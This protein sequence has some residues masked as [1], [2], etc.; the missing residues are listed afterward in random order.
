[1]S[2][3]T[4]EPPRRRRLRR[5]ARLLLWSAAVVAVLVALV[6]WLGG[7][8]WARE[9]VR[10]LVEARLT[11][12][13]GREVSIASVDYGVAPLH[14]SARGIT[15]AGARSDEPPF[16]RVPALRV[17]LRIVGVLD[18]K[19]DV[20]R[21]DVERPV[22]RLVFY[23]DGSDNLPRIRSGGGGGG[24]L[25]VRL[26]RLVVDEG[27]VLFDE[28][29]IPVSVDAG[30][31]RATLE[32]EAA[33][34]LPEK[35]LQ[36]MVVAQDLSALLPGAE[37]WGG[38]LSARAELAPGRLMVSGGRLHGPDL[39][40]RFEV[41]YHWD[42]ES[43]GGEVDVDADGS[44]HLVRRLGY[45]DSELDGPFALH[46]QVTLGEQTS[47][48]GRLTSPRADFLERRFENLEAVLSGDTDGLTVELERAA[49]AGGTLTATVRVESSGDGGASPVSVD[50]EAQDLSAAA[51][52]ADLDLGDSVLAG[53]RGRANGRARYRFTT[54]APL[55]GDGYGTVEVDAVQRGDDDRLPVSGTVPVRVEGG[56]L[57]VT[58]ARLTAPGQRLR[59]D[60]EYDLQRGTG[61][62]TYVLDV[63]RLGRLAAALPRPPSEKPPVWLPTGGTGRVEGEVELTGGG[64]YVL[65]A[66]V[67]LAAV[68]TGVLRLDHVS[69]P[70]QVADGVLSTGD[71]V[72]E[73]QG[74]RLLLAGRWDLETSA[75]EADYR[76]SSD[77][78]APLLA[79][80]PVDGPPPPWLPGGGSG[81]VAGRLALSPGGELSGR[82]ELDLENV[83]LPDVTLA[84]V[85]GSMEFDGGAL[86]D[87]RLE[88]SSDGGALVAVGSVPLPPI[89]GVVGTP[90]WSELPLQLGVD[91]ADWPAASLPPFLRVAVPAL[92][93]LSGDLSGM[94]EAGGT[95][96]ELQVRLE[97]SAA[98]LQVAGV[99]LERAEAQARLDG[100][101][102]TLERLRVVAPAGEVRAAGSVDLDGGA[103]SGTLVADGLALDRPPLSTRLPAALGGT[104][105]LRVE[106][107]GTLEQPRVELHTEA[108]G[109]QVAGRPLGDGEEGVARLAATWEA[110]RLR[111]DGSLL[112]IVQLAGGGRLTPEEAELRLDVSEADLG[113][114][115][116]MVTDAPPEGLDGSLAGALTLAGRFDA[117]AGPDLALTLDRVRI[118][119]RGHALENLEP[120][121]F[122]LA[123]AGDG[124]AGSAPR[125]IVDSLFLGEPASEGEA[126][127]TGEIELAGDG[128]LDLRTQAELS[129]DWLALLPLD[130]RFDGTLRALGRVRGTVS[131]PRLDGQGE[132]VEGEVILPD[133]PHAL[134]SVNAILLFYPQRVVLDQ[135]T[136]RLAGGRVRSAGQVSLPDG[137]R[138]L[139]YRFQAEATGVA[140]RYPE[141][142]LLRGDASLTASTEPDGRLIAGQVSLERAFYLEDVPVGIT[143]LL[144]QVL[145]PSRLEAGSAD[146]ELAATRLNVAVRGPGALRVRN[147]VADLSG[148]VDLVLR[149]NLADPVL[150]G[151]V[152]LDAGGKIV[153]SDTEY[154]VERGLLT[155]AN[156]YRID[157]VIDL[158]ATTEVRNYDITLN[159][160]GTLDRLNA[161]FS[162]DPPLADLEVVS[163]LTLGRPLGAEQSLGGGTAAAAGSGGAGQAAEE[164]LYGQA[165]SLVAERVNRL[166]GFDRFRVSPVSGSTTGSS[167]LA[168][169]VGQQISRDLFVTY[170][171]DPSTPEVDVVQVEWQVQDNVVVVLTREGDGTYAVDVQ[172][173]RR[174]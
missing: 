23:P 128:D 86:R 80:V 139:D 72:A 143:Q 146:P 92:P 110:D 97:L 153:Y 125:L 8:P 36:A 123:L 74:Q 45:V 25:E 30:P 39:S 98:P 109:V 78:L 83:A 66:G 132:M 48:R 35:H 157:P 69:A 18:P 119:Y 101:R 152:A 142:F 26:G 165:A 4:T 85:T 108:R 67:E 37:P 124:T 172:V 167:N 134:E 2:A 158:A 89:G 164:L 151:Q 79:L 160:A 150:F 173:E 1:M 90:D 20:E 54:D 63:E 118:A 140:V 112:G 141:G 82:G 133:F 88:I 19:V 40:A 43:R 21:V 94:I 17:E 16:A 77:D 27:E 9:R 81:R 93:E 137:E 73:G 58:G 135:M 162:S 12:Y 155:F 117:P 145:E 163:L 127:L 62:F 34:A 56:V 136:A 103:L 41:V 99:E 14:V 120:V 170:T 105:E 44:L 130:M 144:Q 60:G 91:V 131:D 15:V 38:T 57:R 169:T 53:V 100:R 111:V 121:V 138:P 10:A 49:H 51:L 116:R 102:V 65:E 174:Y 84:A 46:A 42:E 64:G 24:N 122:R 148:D 113:D 75:G 126:F 32:G 6:W 13:L 59:A 96:R 115:L 159:L 107:G 22:V 149:G 147:N 87:L 7:R 114:L 28:R 129:A 52:L 154:R 161:T 166:F 29:R 70:L 171:R 156:P 11:E 50:A 68:E 106:L 104:L 31:V 95:L 3:P 168:L 33:T 47:V 76:L 71:L 5:L 55:D 61:R